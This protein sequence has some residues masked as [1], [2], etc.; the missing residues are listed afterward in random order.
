[1]KKSETIMQFLRAGYAEAQ[2]M[3]QTMGQGQATGQG[4]QAKAV[5]AGH[6]A[7]PVRPA[8][9]PAY[10]TVGPQEYQAQPARYRLE[11]DATQHGYGVGS[12]PAIYHW[13]VVDAQTGMIM[14]F[15]RSRTQA[16][17]YRKG[18]RAL[19]RFVG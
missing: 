10:S 15:G 14:E 11:V 16:K 19:T 9:V 6:P 12:S 5:T 8:M 4:H 3:V 13:R 1:M 2:A 7:T 17:A 18:N